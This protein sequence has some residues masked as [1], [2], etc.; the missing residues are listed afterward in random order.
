MAILGLYSLS[1]PIIH[2]ISGTRTY[3]INQTPQ[4]PARDFINGNQ[5]LWWYS[6][7]DAGKP[8]YDAASNFVQVISCVRNDHHLIGVTIHTIDWWTDMRDLPNWG[9]LI[10]IPALSTR[11]QY[12]C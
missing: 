10:H 5:L 3:H 7:V 4:H 6:G 2:Q 11:S 8:G 1:N 9:F 12:A